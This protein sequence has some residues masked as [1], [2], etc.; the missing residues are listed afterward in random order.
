MSEQKAPAQTGEA[1]IRC[2]LVPLDGAALLIPNAL[3][4][5]VAPFQAPVP[6]AGPSWLLGHIEWRGLAVPLISIE[7]LAGMA[8]GQ[9]QRMSRAIVCNTLNGNS[10]M[11]FIAVLS[12]AIPRMQL[13]TAG[14]LPSSAETAQEGLL[15]RFQ[16]GDEVLLIPDLDRIEQWLCDAGIVVKRGEM[17]IEKV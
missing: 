1:A 9:P 14:T 8:G 7:S 12:C 5:E 13:V 4:S 6:T 15:C 10:Q 17:N 16:Q 3:V 11:P 2:L